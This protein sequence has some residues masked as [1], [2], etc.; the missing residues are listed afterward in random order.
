MGRISLFTLFANV[1]YDVLLLFLLLCLGREGRTVAHRGWIPVSWHLFFSYSSP[2]SPPAHPQMGTKAAS[3]KH[4]SALVRPKTIPFEQT[5]NKHTATYI[6]PR[7][8][9]MGRALI[10]IQ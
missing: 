1:D 3:G 8:W 7:R 2:P 9:T 4:F 6:H 10:S 5:I